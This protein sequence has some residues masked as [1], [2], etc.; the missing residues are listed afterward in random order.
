M[1]RLVS[2]GRTSRLKRFLSI[3]KY[4]GASRKRMNRGAAAHA[5]G[6]ASRPIRGLSRGTELGGA[7]DTASVAFVLNAVG[8]KYSFMARSSTR[9]SVSAR[10]LTA[11]TGGGLSGNNRAFRRRLRATLLNTLREPCLHFLLDPRDGMC[12]DLDAHR[13]IPS[14]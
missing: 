10:T 14:P 5:E 3:P 2:A 11:H 7:Y 13:E 1:G 8:P 12:R 6:S 9:C 4:R